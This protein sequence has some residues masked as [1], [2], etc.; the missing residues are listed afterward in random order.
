MAERFVEIIL[1]LPPLL[2]ALTVH[3]YLH[4]YVA[5]RMGDPTAKWSGRLTFNPL[6]HIDPIGLIAFLFLKFGWAKPVPVNPYNF[7]NFRKGMVLTSLAGP[8]SNFLL[9]IISG[10][11]IRLLDVYS[12]PSFLISMLGLSIYFNLLIFAFNLIPVP[13]LDGSKVLFYTLPNRYLNLAHVL[14]QY[15]LFILVGL[16]FIDNLGIPVLWGWIGP[17]VKFFTILFGG[18]NILAI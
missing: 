8:G 18:R 17:F 13:P 6:K 10:L 5:Y 14:E 1:S 15:G 12:A 4:G 2:L 9:A 3:E 7:Y 11:L 16:I